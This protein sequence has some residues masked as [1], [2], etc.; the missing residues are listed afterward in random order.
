VGQQTVSCSVSETWWIIALAAGGG[1]ITCSGV[2][3]AALQI[4]WVRTLFNR[5]ETPGFR[6][7]LVRRATQTSGRVRTF[8]NTKVLRQPGPQVTLPAAAAVV[9]VAALNATVSAKYGKLDSS[10]T[11]D[12]KID[13]LDDRLRETVDRFEQNF[14]T[15]RNDHRQ[16]D[17]RITN[18]QRATSDRV[19][20]VQETVVRNATG[21]LRLSTWSV[22]LILLGT[23]LLTLAACLGATA[24][25]TC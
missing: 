5:P 10:L 20:Q 9:A 13:M 1:L 24:T 14:T 7:W 18:S 17:N 11:P 12:E 25:V 3:L 6:R 22:G 23:A 21:T 4:H 8:V 15:V 2:V 19:D 16:L